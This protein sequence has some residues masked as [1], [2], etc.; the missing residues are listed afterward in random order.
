MCLFWGAGLSR[1]WVY[2]T[3]VVGRQSVRGG[4]GRFLVLFGVV[5]D[6]G[7]VISTYL[8]DVFASRTFAA[9][10]EIRATVVEE[11]TTLS[12][13]TCKQVTEASMLTEYN[14]YYL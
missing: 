5:D 12:D 1:R 10:A 7:V 9:V 13:T 8:E 3:V 11:Q 14:G 6:D 2:D 4:V